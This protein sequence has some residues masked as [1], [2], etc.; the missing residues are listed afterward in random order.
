M[1]WKG[2]IE[3]TFTKVDLNKIYITEKIDKALF[4]KTELSTYVRTFEVEA[5][6]K[7]VLLVDDVF[8]KTLEAGTYRFWRNDTTIKI[9]KA[10]MRQL[11]L[12][13]AGQELLTNDKANV[14]INFYAQYKVIDIEKSLVGKQRL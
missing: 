13:V 4:A 1:F 2:L 12:E 5:Y 10:D 6:E 9:G 7:A 8:V 3:Y 14:R 11:Q